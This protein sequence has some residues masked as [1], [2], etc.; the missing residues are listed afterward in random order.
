MSKYFEL[1]FLWLHLIK[2]S[3]EFIVIWLDYAKKKGAFYET[4]C[5]YNLH[6]NFG[7]AP[8][9]VKFNPQL[10]FHNLNAV[11]WNIV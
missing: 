7:Q 9:V 4:P 8:T 3:C 11:Y 1:V 2:I 6:H 10:I 5:T